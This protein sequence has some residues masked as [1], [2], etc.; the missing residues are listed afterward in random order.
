MISV[1]DQV[2]GVRRPFAKPIQT[3]MSR[4][5]M[6]DPH[7]SRSRRAGMSCDARRAWAVITRHPER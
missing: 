7:S 2:I 1:A 3:H 5:L 4:P 6:V